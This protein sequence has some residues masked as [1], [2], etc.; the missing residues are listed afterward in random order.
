MTTMTKCHRGG[1]ASSLCCKG[2][3]HA[4]EAKQIAH[5]RVTLLGTVHQPRQPQLIVA[6]VH[7][8]HELIPVGRCT[9][10]VLNIVGMLLVGLGANGDGLVVAPFCLSTKLTHRP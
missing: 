8:C 6:T 2:A 7:Q 1:N 3:F 5:L 10:V 9:P 4:Q